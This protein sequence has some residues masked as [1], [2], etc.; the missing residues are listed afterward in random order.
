MTA[1]T[2]FLAVEGLARRFGDT[3]ALVSC[4]FDVRGG[5]VHALIGENG[6][7]KST[8]VKILSG[9][10]YPDRGVLRVNG[11]DIGRLASPSRAARVGIVSVFQEILVVEH[12]SVLDNIW[13]GFDGIF[14]QKLSVKEKLVRAN[15][16]LSHL[17]SGYPALDTPMRWL[18]LG[19]RQLA[20]IARALVRD[21]R[22]LILDEAT[23]ALDI[24]NR[25]RLFEELRRRRANGVAV[26]FI[27][28]RM[29][30]IAEISD[31]VTVLRSGESVATLK[32]GE[33]AEA[34]LLRLMSGR[35]AE[36]RV[37]GKF[38]TAPAYVRS[39]AEAASPV[40]LRAKGLV[41][42]D[43]C[44]PY[45]FALRAGEIVGL[46]GLEGHGQDEFAKAIAGLITPITGE[47]RAET[48]GRT[49][50]SLEDAARAKVAYVPRDRKSEGTFEPLSILENFAALTLKR[51]LR[52]RLL[53]RR[54]MRARFS[55]YRSLLQIRLGRDADLITS[56]SGGNQQK[57]L[58][59]RQLAAE[60]GVLVLNDPTR[61]V[62][63]ATKWDI[64]ALLR[65]LAAQGVAIVLLSTELE[66]HI[67]LTD[68]VLVFRSGEVFDEVNRE[69]VNHTRLIAAMFGRSSEES[70]SDGLGGAEA[71][72]ARSPSEAL[73]RLSRGG[74][75]R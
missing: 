43:G 2:P 75:P 32:R 31:R 13:L 12:L 28:H 25:D 64:Y 71:P 54:R 74:R 52:Y 19:E 3:Q 59:A 17:T 9:V 15:D 7:G 53:A 29:D 73:G 44:Q 48:A 26:V 62:D 36:E 10:L 60:P 56:L 50:A 47:V 22:L 30:E 72:A 23:S 16:T 35:E 51:D 39:R 49:I 24:S 11:R 70:I 5:E 27:S 45:D 40:V 18:N 33:A 58:I 14:R 57:V 68:R 65:R 67:A 6:S 42:R 37:R 20:V 46:A 69:E 61:G 1:D 4:S 41:L 8:L 66:E 21:P 38:E 55:L 34:T 63:L